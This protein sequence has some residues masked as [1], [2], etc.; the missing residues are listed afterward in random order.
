MASITLRS[1]RKSFGSTPVLR[2]V[3]LA[4]GDGEFVSLLGPSGCGKST[5]LRIIAGL[6]SHDAGE[7]LMGDRDVSAL[8][9]SARNLAMVFQSYALYPHLSVA[10]NIM[11][12]LKMRD[13][14]ALERLPVLGR[15]VPGRSNK[16]TAIRAR[17]QS[18]A[19]TLRLGALLERK[20]GQLSGGQRQRVAL[21][22]AMVRDPSAFLMD[23]P[24]SN[25]DAALRVHMRT[26]IAQLHRQLGTTFIYVT[27]DQV[28]AMTMSDRIAVMLE[29]EIVQVGSPTEV[30]EDPRDI[31]VAQFIGSPKINLIPGT[32]DDAGFLRLGETQV[33]RAF[34]APAGTALRLGIRPEHLS[35]ADPAKAPLAGRLTHMENLGAEVFVYL[36]GVTEAPVVAR[37]AP[38][39]GRSLTLGETVGLAFS[40]EDLRVFGPDGLRINASPLVLNTH[41]PA[42]EGVSAHG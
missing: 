25:L 33:R 34:Q 36:E 30:Y 41:R 10:D 26:E 18:A 29:G 2:G 14:S 12:P 40:A 20:P 8:S 27:H 23:E 22:R 19:D 24:L 15:L 9:P 7:L 5:L 6:E 11:V 37:L 42:L 31:R 32:I 35:L 16:L 28:E 38:H 3:S 39:E 4:I 1:L 21:G 13:L 17:M